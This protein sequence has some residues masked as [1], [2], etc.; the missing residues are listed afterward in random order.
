MADVD[1]T[2]VGPDGNA[3]Q[4]VIE[5]VAAARDAGVHLGFATGRMRGAV[6]ALSRALVTSGPHVLF[7]GAEVRHDGERVHAW[8]LDGEQVQAILDVCKRLDVYAELYTDDGYTVTRDDPRA[9]PHWDLLG[10]PPDDIGLVAPE[11]RIVKITFGLFEDDPDDE[12]VSAIEELG[13]RPGPATSP[14]TP[15]IRYVN[16]THAD[17][18]KGTALRLAADHLGIGLDEVAAIGD[19][20]NDLPMLEVAGTAVAMGQA[21]DEIRDVAHLV[22]PSVTDDGAAVAIRALIELE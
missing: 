15:G 12:V 7:N 18:D 4:A 16:A 17:A 6:E 13:L 21:P 9:H 20:P 22:A 3:A 2:L 11:G 10:Q 5:A 19:A 8:L 1:G 14:V